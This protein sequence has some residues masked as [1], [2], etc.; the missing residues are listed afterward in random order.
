MAEGLTAGLRL[1]VFT[2]PACSGCTNAVRLAWKA[3]EEHADV[4]LRTVRLENQEGLD[5]A[6]AEGVKTIP[7]IILETATEELERWV[8][9]PEPGVVAAALE[10]LM[11]PAVAVE[12]RA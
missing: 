11:R 3:A 2:H 10:K 6:Y 5:E 4:E 8:G 7:T 1:R 12:N 9:S